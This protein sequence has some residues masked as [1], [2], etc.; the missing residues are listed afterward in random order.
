[1]DRSQ[2]LSIMNSAKKIVQDLSSLG[3][4]S[5]DMESDPMTGMAPEETEGLQSWGQRPTEIQDSQRPP[6]TVRES[7][8]QSAKPFGKKPTMGPF[9]QQEDMADEETDFM[10]IEYMSQG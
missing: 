3:L 4:E 5:G 1:M 7:I 8:M 2:L 9:G 10:P 6:L